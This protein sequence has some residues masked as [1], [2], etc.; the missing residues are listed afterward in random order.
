MSDVSSTSSGMTGAGGGNKLRITGM[1]TGLDVDAMVKKMMTAEQTKLD[2]AKQNK[3]YTQWKQEAY[4]DIIKDVKDLQSSFFDSMSSDKN[5]LSSS[6][7]SPYTVSGLNGNT[8][9]TS[10]ATFTPGVGAKT[11]KYSMHVTQLATASVKEGIIAPSAQSSG[12]TPTN[13]NGNIGFSVDGGAEQTITLS[14]LSGTSSITDVITKIQ[15]EID[16][17]SSLKGK[18]KVEANGTTNIK[19]EALTDSAVKIS[20]TKT[21]VLADM[22]KLKGRNI[23]ISTSTTMSDLGVTSDSYLSLKYNGSSKEITIKS[24]DK[25]SDVISKINSET[26]GAVKASYSQLTGKFT[27]QTANTGSTQSLQIVAPTSGGSMSAATALGITTGVGTTAQDAKVTITSPGG[28]GTD[29]LKSSNSFDIDGMNYSLSTVGDASVSVGSDANKVYDKINDFIT[30]YNTLVDKIQ[31]KLTE[32]KNSDYKPLTD[33]QKE[34]MSSSEITAWETKAKVGILRKDSNLQSMFDDLRSAFTTAVAGTQLKFGQYSSDS[35]G[36]DMSNDYNK[37]GHIEMV[38]ASKLK[39]A[40]A[41]HPDEVLKMFTNVSTATTATGKPY[42]GTSQEYR[43]DGI[44]NRVKTIFEK[45]V[46]STNVTLNTAILTSYANKQYDFST[47]A[48]GSKNTLPD[49][50]Y[51]E[52][53]LISKIQTSMSEKQERY[54]KQFSQLETA[55]NT[56]NAQQAQ[57]SSFTS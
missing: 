7:F 21:T 55:M 11:G 50:L 24:T 18:I 1:S 43:E 19:F 31:T 45:N 23:N 28:T 53:L 38:D 27:I 46:G 42:D 33:A 10:I 29:I 26:S 22:D 14:G 30:K 54:Y 8:V 48:I 6:N 49:Q 3:Q 5:V 56:L 34:S 15:A 20:D 44:F 51:Q 25:I 39:T 36:I 16:A 4:Q 47:S 52:Q 13:W 32:K 12:F 17:N 41:N 2:K 57:L 35:I 9:D 37:P 40:I